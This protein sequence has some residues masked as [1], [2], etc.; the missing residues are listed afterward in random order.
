MQ[1]KTTDTTTGFSDKDIKSMAKL[2][3]TIPRDFHELARLPRTW[4]GGRAPLRPAVP[5]DAY[6]GRVV[7]FPDASSRIDLATLRQLAHEDNSPPVASVGSSRNARNN[8]WCCAQE[9]N[10]R[11]ISTRIC[12]TPFD[13]SATGGRSLRLPRLRLLERQDGVRG[14]RCREG[15]SPQRIRR[16]RR[17]IWTKGTVNPTSRSS[18]QES[19]S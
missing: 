11:T 6:V 12:W 18:L 15:G 16:R 7:S 9:W 19:M 8:T 5:V 17:T 4:R 14:Q 1:L 10:T 2:N 3:F 13:A